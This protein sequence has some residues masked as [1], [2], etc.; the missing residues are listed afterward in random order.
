MTISHTDLYAA[1]RQYAD[2]PAFIDFVTLSFSAPAARSKAADHDALSP[3]SAK[4]APVV[5]VYACELR[6]TVEV[7]A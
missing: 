6:A 4:E 5:G 7:T 3:M 2:G 1:V